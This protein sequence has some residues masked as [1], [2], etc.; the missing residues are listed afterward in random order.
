V[1]ETDDSGWSTLHRSS[2]PE[3]LIKRAANEYA[4]ESL[5]G[6]CEAKALLQQLDRVICLDDEG[7]ED[8]ALMIDRNKAV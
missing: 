8:A 7:I 3:P 2:L 5:A 6:D 4:T 1:N